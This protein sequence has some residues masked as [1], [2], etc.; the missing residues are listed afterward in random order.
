MKEVLRRGSSLKLCEIAAGHADIYPRLGPTHEWNIAA[1]DAILRAAG[2]SIRDL[3]GN[4]LRYIGADPG[5]RNPNFVAS[6]FDWRANW[7]A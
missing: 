4:P 7:Q 3:E 2:G 5:Y 1:G 6:S